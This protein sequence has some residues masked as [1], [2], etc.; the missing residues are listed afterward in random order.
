MRTL[1]EWIEYSFSILFENILDTQKIEIVILDQ[2]EA[3]NQHMVFTNKKVFICLP[4]KTVDVDHI[5]P[6]LESRVHGG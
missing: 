5:L 6:V 2:I 3:Q 4:W 1:S